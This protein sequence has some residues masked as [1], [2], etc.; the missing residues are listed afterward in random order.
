MKVLPLKIDE[1]LVDIY[2]YFYYSVKTIASLNDYLE[3]CDVEFKDCEKD[4]FFYTVVTN[5]L[6]LTHSC[7]SVLL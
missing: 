3:F 1:T 4:G 6:L 2:Y 5:C 7:T